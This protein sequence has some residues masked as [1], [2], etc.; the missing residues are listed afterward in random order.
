MVSVKVLAV[1]A[2]AAEGEMTEMAESNLKARIEAIVPPRLERVT[3]AEVL[4]L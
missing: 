4:L 2:G 3:L 1:K